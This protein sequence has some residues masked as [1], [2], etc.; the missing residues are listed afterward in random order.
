MTFNPQ[1][2]SYLITAA[3]YSK[4]FIAAGHPAL[5]FFRFRFASC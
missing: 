1:L 5:D 3:T 2:A 4:L